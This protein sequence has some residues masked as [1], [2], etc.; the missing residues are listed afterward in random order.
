M[1]D[2]HSLARAR[3]QLQQRQLKLAEEYRASHR[4]ERLRFLLADQASLTRYIYPSY[5]SAELVELPFRNPYS[6]P[7]AFVVD[8]DDALGHLSLVQTLDEWRS[9]KALHGLTTPAE[10]NLLLKGKQLWLQAQELVYIPL[11]Y[12]GWQCGQVVLE[13]AAAAAARA[14]RRRGG[15]AAAALRRQRRVVGGAPSRGGR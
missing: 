1:A 3:L 5:G 2:E 13:G 9:L 4:E 6:E 8:W 10:D 12:Q 7:H 15:G 14:R 11:K